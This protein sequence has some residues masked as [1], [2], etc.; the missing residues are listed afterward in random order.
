M[1]YLKPGSVVASKDNI[2]IVDSVDDDGTIHMIE[3]SK[4]KERELTC[5]DVS[6]MISNIEVDELGY[7][8]M[9]NT[10]WYEGIDKDYNRS[11][12]LGAHIFEALDKTIKTL[13]ECIERGDKKH[14]MDSFT[15]VSAHKFA[16]EIL[17]DNIGLNSL[18]P[19]DEYEISDD[20]TMRELFD[21]L[22]EETIIKNTKKNKAILKAMKAIQKDEPVEPLKYHSNLIPKDDVIKILNES[23]GLTINQICTKINNYCIPTN[24]TNEISINEVIKNCERIATI[25]SRDLDEYE[26]VGE[27]DYIINNCKQDIDEN[28]Q[29][30]HWLWQL[31]ELNQIFNSYNTNLIAEKEFATMVSHVLEK[32]VN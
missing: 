25:R 5:K 12:K 6:T 27:S 28:L 10:G 11:L 14:D 19:K 7:P 16:K 17:L 26:K 23:F 31:K 8:H 24:T 9:I 22:G 3:S 2:G 30:A 29:F 13:D 32:G 21:L 15:I 4:E 20:D 18:L 1:K